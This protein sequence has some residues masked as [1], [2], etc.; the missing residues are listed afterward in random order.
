MFS[1]LR[2]GSNVYILQKP[3]KLRIGV[4]SSINTP[5]TYSSYL[6]NQTV[7]I[8]VKCDQETTEFKQLPSSLGITYYDNGNTVISDSREI[9]TTEVENMIKTSQEVI[10]SIPYHEKIIT[11]GEEMLKTLNPQFAKQKDQEQKINN[12]EN[13][14][15]NMESKLDNITELLTKALN[16]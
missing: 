1:A 9:I 4:V 6:P 15:G 7:D 14:V 5:T 3:D 13:K 8:T 2:Q 10:N 11:S 16:K 12:L